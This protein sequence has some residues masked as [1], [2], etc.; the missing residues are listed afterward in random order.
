MS[1]RSTVVAC[2]TLGVLAVAPAADA[3]V[4]AD[5]ARAMP[6]QKFVMKSFSAPSSMRAGRRT[7][8]SGRVLNLRGHRAG[9]GRLTFSLRR[10]R[11]SARGVYLRS[12]GTTSD[13]NRGANVRKTLGGHSRRFVLRLLV[14]A[15]TPPRRYWLRA[16]VRRGSGASRASCR[17]RRVR[18]TRPG[19][20]ATPPP[21]GGGTAPGADGARQSLRASLTDQN[22]YFLMADRFANGDTGNDRG[23]LP[24]DRLVSG[25]DPT[26]KGFYHGGDLKGLTQRLDYIKGLGTTAIWLTPSFKNK[27]VQGPAGQETAGY[28]G[29]WITDFTQIDPHLGTN[30]DLGDLVTAAH[31]RGMKVFFDI[32]TNHTA[33]VIAYDQ[34]PGGPAPYGYV[35]KDSDPYR[36]SSGAPFD[37]RDYAG[38]SSFPPLS[39]ADSFPFVPRNPAGSETPGNVNHKVPEWLNDVTA[40]HNRGDTTFTGENSLYGDFFGLDDLFTEQPRVVDGMVDIYKTWIRDFQIDGFRIDTMKHVNDEFWQTFAPQILDYAHQQGRSQFFLFGEVFDTSRPFQSHFTTHDRV[41]AVLDFPFQAAAQRFA[42]NSG[43]TDAL[44]DFFLADDWYTDADSNVYQMPTFLGNHDMGRIGFFLRG[45]NAGASDEEIFARD[46]LAH[47]LMYFS[48]GNP[49]VYYGDEQ[50][51]VGDGGDQDARQD[52]FPSQVASYNDDDDIATDATP[53]D[54]N[55]DPS[56]RLYQAIADLAALTRSHPAL[57]NGPEQYRASTG[58][59]GI[60]AFSRLDRAGQHEYVVALNNSEQAQTAT[61][62]TSAGTAATFERIYGDGGAP[63]LV[64]DAAQRLH[65]AVPALSAVVYRSRGAIPASEAAPKLSLVPLPEGG[66]ARDRA[67][68]RA[69]VDGDSFYDVTFEA[70]AGDGPWT[71]IGTDDNSPYRVFH[72]ISDL[73]PGTHVAYRAIVL[74]NAGHTRTSNVGAIDV[75]APSITLTKPDDGGSVRESAP[76]TAEVTPDHNDYVVTFQRSV[77]GGA[78]TTVATDDS[79]P[80]YSASDDVSA[81]SPGTEI[82]YRAILTYAPGATVTS[83]TRTVTIGTP[84]TVARIHYKRTDGNYAAWGLH[85]WGDGLGP[86][87]ATPEWTNPKAFEGTDSYGAFH[88]IQIADDTQSVGFIVHGRPPTGNPD[89]K[90]TNADRFFTP[91]DHPDIWLKE[92][93]ATIYFSPPS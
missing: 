83:A 84:V 25:Y 17:S 61:V 11:S 62:P 37:D 71:P 24:D 10:S 42:A 69:F 66:E 34:K 86:G 49:V 60:Y 5:A 7:T 36:T 22:F 77:A 75:A 38:T 50:G 16:C 15:G 9:T 91:I 23:G 70:R 74:D 72:D 6:L 48:R 92:G 78:W 46:R 57:R 33:D 73:A 12:R 32:I 28:H 21:G 14:P 64:S 58:G 54:S 20:P 13:R 31:S 80:V 41:Q 3:R 67:E 43:P 8:V 85:L 35:S 53:A 76:L 63:A 81:F 90:D 52:M 55:F 19:P 87:E 2:A 27:P 56:H 39:A 59:A 88:S 68:V 4:Q 51:F 40:Y 79:Q 93:D 1:F 89:T 45:A 44:R 26:H 30:Q 82:S 18:V 65:V 47:E 29:Y